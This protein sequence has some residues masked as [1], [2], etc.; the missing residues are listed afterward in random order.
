MI[1]FVILAH[2]VVNAQI[3]AQTLG[4]VWLLVGVVALVVLLVTGRRPG[5]APRPSVA[6]ATRR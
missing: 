2:V 1:G 4:F 5:P 6:V 3:A